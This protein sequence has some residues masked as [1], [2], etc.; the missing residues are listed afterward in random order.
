MTWLDSNVIR[1]C[2]YVVVA[3]MMLGARRRERR[4]VG[5]SDEIS[6]SFWIV[7]CVFLLAIAVGRVV[8]AADLVTS[9]GRRA[10]D[11]GGWSA[12]RRPVQAVVVGG[13]GVTWFAVVAVAA[14]RTPER[15][16]RYLPVAL[17]IVSLA[18]FA[19]VRVISLHQVDTLMY[20]TDVAGVRI[21]TVAD[22]ALLAVTGLTTWWCPPATSPRTERS[23]SGRSPTERTT[24]ARRAPEKSAITAD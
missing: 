17:A 21:V 22:L 15:R 1:T 24:S 12:L 3:G 13:V 14:S 11:G 2:G 6:P 4:R 8:E 9:L 5:E 23:S 16:R 19:V 18:A 7:S 20:R 10:A